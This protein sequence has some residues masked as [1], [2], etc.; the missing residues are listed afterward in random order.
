MRGDDR[1]RDDPGGASLYGGFLVMS[2][3]HTSV[4]RHG[5]WVFALLAIVSVFLLASSLGGPSAGLG[6][7]AVYAAIPMN[8]TM[9][10][11]HG[12]SNVYAF[13]L[14]PLV[15]LA[16]G[17]AL[18]SR[19][20]AGPR[21]AFLLALVLVALAAAHRLTF[22]VAVGTLVVIAAA[23][24]LRPSHRRGLVRFGLITAA[25]AVPVG[26]LV[27]V[28]LRARSAGT[29][30]VLSYKNY[31]AGKIDLGL[32]ASDLTFPVTVAGLLGLALL[33][34]GLRSDRALLAPYGLL[35]AVVALGYGWIAHLPTVYYRL[36]YFM[37]LVMA[38]AIG[39][40]ATMLAR[41]PLRRGRLTV[42]GGAAVAVA[43]VLLTATTV[44][45]AHDRGPTVRQYYEW[46]SPTSLE[47]LSRVQELTQPGDVVVTDRCWAFL[48]VWLLER[49]ILAGL[50]PIDILPRSEERPAA[51][52]REVLYGPPALARGIAARNRARYVLVNPTCADPE[53]GG[54]RVP[55]TG[56][57]IYVST[58]LVV[59]DLAPAVEGGER[60]RGRPERD[61]R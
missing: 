50:D 23:G 41:S 55:R 25:W 54:E 1:F 53:T 29:G 37:P 18:R 45:V 39:M 51:Q 38:V 30:G 35:A 44:V 33:V 40:A 15:V 59:L 27:A 58:R 42:G 52:A 47:G 28:D 48:A 8:I 61:A 14:L 60:R 26:L 43:V 5:I 9:L 12:L 24:L 57:P 17:W 16:G 13:C 10:G 22:L 31:L 7:A 6:A 34:R 56:T 32:A 46:V 2:G 3:V 11:W 36:V 21:W 20:G 4:L 19:A 49:R